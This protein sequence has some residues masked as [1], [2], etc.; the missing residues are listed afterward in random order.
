MILNGFKNSIFLNLL[1]ISGY[2]YFVLWL[3]IYFIIRPDIMNWHGYPGAD[4][5]LVGMAHAHLYVD[6]MFS[7]FAICFIL[8]FILILLA[9]IEVFLR[10]KAKIPRFNGFDNFLYPILF[11]VGLILQLTPICFVLVSFLVH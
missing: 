3:Y 11:K 5:E 7:L 8:S 10:K 4:P 9:I 6:I 2:L 1:S